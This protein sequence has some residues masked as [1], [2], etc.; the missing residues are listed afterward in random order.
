VSSPAPPKGGAG[1]L[2]LS[3][4]MAVGK[5]TVGRLLSQRLELP[6]LD[7]DAHI[8]ADARET[9][10]EIFA[11]RGEAGFRALER[12]ALASVAAHPTQVVA[13]GGGALV[14]DESRALAR[15]SG[16]VL[17]LS[18]GPE[19]L[20]SRGGD[21]AGRPLF[22]D[23]EARLADRAA[24]YADA[25][26]QVVTDDRSPEQVADAALAALDALGWRP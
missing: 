15:R 3:G 8:Q 17:T 14:D 19:T 10:P 23:L 26:A 6:F 22:H 21:G 24:A 1:N 11:T 9:I 20:R 12:A 25:D 7:L 18:A 13:L 16:V 2:Y 5:S 4:F